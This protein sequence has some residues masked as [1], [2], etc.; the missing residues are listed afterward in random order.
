MT[1][2]ERIASDTWRRLGHAGALKARLGEETLT[3]LLILDMLPHQRTNGFWIHHPTRTQEHVFGAD[4]LLWI[5]YPGRNRPPPRATG[6]K[7]LSLRALRG[8]RSQGR[9]RD[10]P[11][12]QVRLV[13]ALVG[14]CSG[15]HALQPC[16]PATAL[17]SAL[18]MLSKV[19]PRAAR[20]YACTLMGHPRRD[21]DSWRS[22]VLGN[23][24][25]RTCSAMAMRFRLSQPYGTSGR[26]F[27]APAGVEVGRRRS[28]VSAP[29]PRLAAD[30]F[31]WI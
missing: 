2:A 29:K 5:R 14:G 15:L 18:A 30:R 27:A 9:V 26:A 7:A 13:R 21:S 6:E 10:A 31:G 3:D 22:Y 12:R 16:G 4:L 25:E 17:Q 11:N 8:A 28:R 24:W 1:P 19:R 20:L 23:T